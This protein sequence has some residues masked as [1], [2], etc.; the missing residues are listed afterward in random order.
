MKLV[1]E[2]LHG[3]PDLSRLLLCPT[4]QLIDLGFNVRGIAPDTHHYHHPAW[5]GLEITTTR[6][7]LKVESIGRPSNPVLISLSPTR[8]DWTENWLREGTL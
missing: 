3:R 8:D 4:V 1:E 6:D 2:V 7:P 5:V